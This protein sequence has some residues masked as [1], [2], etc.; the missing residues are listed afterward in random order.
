MA[1]MQVHHSFGRFFRLALVLLDTNSN[2]HFWFRLKLW[3]L[4]CTCTRYASYPQFNWF[5]ALLNHCFMLIKLY[6]YWYSNE[7]PVFWNI[8]INN[9]KKWKYI[10][11][12]RYR[13]NVKCAGNYLCKV[14]VMFSSIVDDWNSLENGYMI[15]WSHTDCSKYGH[16]KFKKL[17]LKIIANFVPKQITKFDGTLFGILCYISS[18]SRQLPG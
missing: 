2:Q 17:K 7:L 11:H 6:P 14:E 8:I 15:I 1:L 10:S 9:I 5:L 16:A 4:T 3:T 13:I 12:W 18:S